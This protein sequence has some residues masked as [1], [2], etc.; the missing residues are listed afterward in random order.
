MEVRVEVQKAISECETTGLR[1][2]MSVF[3]PLI[4]L[5][6]NNPEVSNV[7]PIQVRKLFVSGQ[8]NNKDKRLSPTTITHAGV[9]A[10][11]SNWKPSFVIPAING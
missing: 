6:T 4:R 8:I 9:R 11:S 10:F 5:I 1:V 7:I 2:S 3:V